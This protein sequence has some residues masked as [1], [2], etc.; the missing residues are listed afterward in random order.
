MLLI[1]SINVPI[2]DKQFDEPVDISIEL[3]CGNQSLPST[4]EGTKLLKALEKASLDTSNHKIELTSVSRSTK[5][6]LLH[7]YSR[8]IEHPKRKKSF[9]G[10]LVSMKKNTRASA[11]WSKIRNSLSATDQRYLDKRYSRMKEDIR[12]NGKGRLSKKDRN[13]S[14]NHRKNHRKNHIKTHRKINNTF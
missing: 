11:N 1:F 10:S 4:G 14:K 6:Y 2:K 8:K 12:D 9:Q 5:Y 13:K 3:F 7:G